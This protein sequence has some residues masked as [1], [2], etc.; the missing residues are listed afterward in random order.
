MSEAIL[1]SLTASRRLRLFAFTSLYVAQGLPIGLITVALPAWLAGSGASAGEVAGFVAISTL[2]WGFKLFAGPMMDRFRFPAMG[3]RRP[4]VMLAQAGLLLALLGLSIVGGTA[5]EIAFLT[6]SC[7]VINSFAA[8]Q[9]VAVDGMAIDVLPEDERGRA[10][11]L[12]AFGQVAGYAGSGA[13]CGWLLVRYGVQVTAGALTI[14]VA[15]IF[16]IAVLLRERDGE[17]LLPWTAGSVQHEEHL[18]ETSWKAIAVNLLRV[19]VLPM[20]LLLMLVTVCWRISDGIFIT[21]IPVVLTQEFG[22]A[23]S[24][25]STWYSNS[26]FVA[27]ALGV[28]LG[29]FIDR[30]GARAFFMAGFIACFITYLALALMTDQWQNPDV[31]I[32][33]MFAVNFSIQVLFVAFIALHMTICWS[34]VAAT[35]FA[36]YMA[37]SN[38]SRS[39]GAKAYGEL[40]PYL[41]AGQETLMM[42][43]LSLLGA[44]LLVFVRLD[45]HRERLDRLKVPEPT[46]D[47]LADVPAR[48]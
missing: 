48:F 19:L 23:S 41:E 45:R 35:Q 43:G 29:P 27:A 46:E 1:P 8:V 14:G 42:A 20:S 16:L 38:L 31:W 13:L 26:S 10:N 17:K 11:A 25:Y 6:W 34:K 24:D 36:V 7:F 47:A 33:G 39:F 18:L 40:S 2:P 21:A 44:V 9:D 28:F 4:W 15:T 22:W 3:G 37:W 12:M 5:D 32:V 30:H